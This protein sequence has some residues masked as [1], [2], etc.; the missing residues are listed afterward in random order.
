M[1]KNGFLTFCFSYI[2]GAGQMYQGY[3]KRGL[4]QMTAF[5]LL[6]ALGAGLFGPI[7]VFA[8]V[9]YMYSFFDSLNLRAQLKM[10]ICPPDDYQFD[11]DEVK[12][13]AR[14]AMQRHNLVGWGLVG[15]GIWLLCAQFI[16]PILS[17]LLY[18]LGVEYQYIDYYLNQI[19]TLVVAGVLI[20]LG[21]RMLRRSKNQP[22]GGD[23]P[24]Y[25][26]EHCD[27]DHDHTDRP[28]Q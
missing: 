12:G 16:G 2:P 5:V 18:W 21:L 6:I 22:G 8:A 4:S 10:G 28:E 14:L 15:V 13:F 26:G 27:C 17:D 7:A 24:P 1:I 3:M 20:W 23:L 19:P 11:L 25:P 9:V